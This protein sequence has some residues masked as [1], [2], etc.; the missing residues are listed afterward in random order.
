MTGGLPYR[1]GDPMDFRRH[2]E[3]A[4]GGG[5]PLNKAVVGLTTDR[6]HCLPRE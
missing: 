1:N 3:G 5:R 6:D 2:C 4:G